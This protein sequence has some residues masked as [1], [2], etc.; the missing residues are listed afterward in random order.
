MP[1]HIHI[2]VWA[3]EAKSVRRFL[4]QCLSI[5]S[6]KIAGMAE[7]AAG[8]GDSTCAAWLAT[9][10]RRTRNG[11]VVRV[12][13]TYTTILC[14]RVAS[15]GP[16]TGGSPARDG[17]STAQAHCASTRYRGSRGCLDTVWCFGISRREGLSGIFCARVACQTGQRPRAQIPKHRNSLNGISYRLYAKKGPAHTSGPCVVLHC[18]DGRSAVRL[19]LTPVWRSEVRG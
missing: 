10:K 1:D 13:T 9:F 5:S 18:G 6:A 2:A 17:T 14:V 3:E 12:W 4:E 19:P 16:M 7:R 15:R 8:R 11:A